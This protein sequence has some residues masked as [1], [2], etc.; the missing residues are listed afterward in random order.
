MAASCDY[1]PFCKLAGN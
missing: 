1:L